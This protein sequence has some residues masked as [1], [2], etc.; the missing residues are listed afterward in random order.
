MD[1]TLAW[2]I[3]GCW[4]CDMSLAVNVAQNILAISWCLQYLTPTSPISDTDNADQQGGSH[5]HVF[6]KL[7]PIDVCVATMAIRR[8]CPLKN[9]AP[10]DIKIGDISFM[11]DLTPYTRSYIN[12]CRSI[13]CLNNRPN[14]NTGDF[15]SR[16]RRKVLMGEK[17]GKEATIHLFSPT[18]SHYYYWALPFRRFKEK[19][20]FFLKIKD[21]RFYG[22]SGVLILT[23]RRYL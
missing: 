21:P 13:F 3:L 2:A 10:R 22:S 16:E 15:F 6:S 5:R 9:F 23:L 11:P 14:Y 4:Y 1:L 8:Y 20:A 19:Q 12:S 7:E 18:I 17:L